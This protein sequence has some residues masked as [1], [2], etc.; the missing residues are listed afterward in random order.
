MSWL[1]GLERR[2]FVYSVASAVSGCGCPFDDAAQAGVC[3][4]AVPPGDVAADHAVLFAVGGVVGAAEGELAQRGETGIR[5]GSSTRSSWAC[6]RSR[7]CWPRPNCPTRLSFLA[8]RCG[9]KLSHYAD[10]RI[11][12]LMPT[13]R[14]CGHAV[15][16]R[17][18]AR[19]GRARRR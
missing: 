1:C 10:V 13:W 18:E 2:G 5:G 4:V 16:V 14:L 6:R 12:R 17:S 3:G 19:A 8:E 9:L 7:R 11:V 15:P